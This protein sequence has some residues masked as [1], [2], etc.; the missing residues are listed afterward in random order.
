MTEQLNNFVQLTIIFKVINIYV[1]T[2]KII[3]D[4]NSSAIMTDNEQ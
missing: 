1:P 4:F 2:Y 3:R